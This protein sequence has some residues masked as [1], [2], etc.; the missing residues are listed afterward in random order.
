MT[1]GKWGAGTPA[2]SGLAGDT[3]AARVLKMLPSVCDE[4]PRQGLS[5]LAAWGPLGA[6]NERLLLSSLQN[7]SFRASGGQSPVR[8]TPLGPAPSVLVCSWEAGQPVKTMECSSRQSLKENQ[9]P[10]LFLYQRFAIK[11]IKFP[12]KCGM[13]L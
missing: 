10:C 12:N 8:V 5:T 1:P 3:A 11:R 7:N 13:G 6:F 4:E 9:L 2:D